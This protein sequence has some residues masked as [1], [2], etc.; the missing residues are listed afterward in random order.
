[1]ETTTVLTATP[2]AQW[3]AGE[4]SAR[5][6]ATL[7]ARELIEDLEP[8]EKALE[9]RKKARREE[10]GTLLIR[11]GEPL[12]V[13]GRTARWVEPSTSESASVRSCAR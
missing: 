11:V 1:M 13:L 5:D 7:I 9:E 2:F 3:E 4:I 8:Q 10:L 12:G 6:A